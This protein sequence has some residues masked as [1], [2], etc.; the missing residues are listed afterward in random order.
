MART[1]KTGSSKKQPV[2]SKSPKDATDKV[3]KLQRPDYKSFR[4]S[5]RIRHERPV[6]ISGRRLLGQG[7]TLIRSHRRMFTLMTILYLFL[8]FTLVRGLT[9]QS[10]L[11]RIKETYRSFNDNP[12]N[13]RT[14]VDLLNVLIGTGNSASSEVGA[15]YQG[16]LLILFS[17]ATIWAL[18]QISTGAVVRLRETFY[19]GMYPLVPFL[20]VLIVMVVQLL[21]VYLG[22]MIYSVVIS[23][24]VAVTWLEQV[25]WLCLVLLLVVWSLYMICSSVFALYI[26]TLPDVTPM[27][28]LR[29]ARHLVRY[30]RW[31][32]M[33]RLLFFPFVLLVVG[34]AMLLPVVI[35]LTPVAEWLFVVIAVA[36]PLFFHAYMYS[37]YRELIGPER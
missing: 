22:L 30:R 37:L 21:P 8:T 36:S 17:L 5:K 15:A 11:S 10:N 12:G 1:T 33:R 31:T 16:I 13:L 18:R 24:G 7:L 23:G 26:A 14:G 34:A 28:A 19:K 35:W 2:A 27:Q 25:L 32:V 9:T 3:R 4:L 6:V 20:L 29:S